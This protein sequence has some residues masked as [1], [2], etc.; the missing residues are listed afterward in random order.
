MLYSW[1]SM[2]LKNTILNKITKNVTTYLAYSI[3]LSV[4]METSHW[5][6]KWSVFWLNV[7]FVFLWWMGNTYVIILNVY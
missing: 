6:T 2:D 5:L 4:T 7:V 1:I 3:W